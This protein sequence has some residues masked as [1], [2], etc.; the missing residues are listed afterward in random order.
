MGE[1]NVI[2]YGGWLAQRNNSGEPR[3]AMMVTAGMVFITMLLRDLNA[4]APLVTMFFLITYAMLNLVLIIEHSLQLISFRPTFTV[5]KSIPWIGLITSIGAMFIINALLS[6]ISFLTVVAVYFVLTKRHLNTPFEDVR[7]GLFISFAEWAAKHAS[8]LTSRQE[9]AWKPNLLVPITS[10]ESVRGDFSFLKDLAY[11]KGS[12]KL[13]GI[14]GED[15]RAAFTSSLVQLNESFQKRG[16]FATSTVLRTDEFANG[17]SFGIQALETAFFKPNVIFLNLYKCA[18][19]KEDVLKIVEE[20]V[21]SKLGVLLFAPHLEAGF[22]QSQVINVWIRDRSPSWQIAW[23]IGNLDL[24]ILIAYQLKRNW[25]ARIRLITV[26]EKEEEYDNAHHFMNTLM[27]LAR[28]PQ[29]EIIV[30]HGDFVPYLSN[31]PLADLN[32]FGMLEEPNFEFIQKTVEL[33]SSSCLFVRDSGFENVMAS[34]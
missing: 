21:F 12:V 15:K 32:I 28:L 29:T 25:K 13:M 8:L 16:V 5:H 26:I 18:D 19:L 31:A 27:D 30:K 6:L 2:P 22:G 17:V 10:A 4:I 23:D 34:H 33:T 24:S 11:P 20:A 3:N 7:S 1:H 14:G 9:R